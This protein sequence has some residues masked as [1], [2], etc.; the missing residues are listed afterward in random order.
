MF[1]KTSSRRL[2]AILLASTAL[3]SAAAANA[4]NVTGAVTDATDTGAVL[5]GAE[6]TLVEL[7]QSHT[8]DSDGQFRFTNIP[9]GNY[10]LRVT[11]T[12]ARTELVSI[13]VPATGDVSANVLLA[14]ADGTDSNTILVIGQRANLNSSISRQR[15]AD[16]VQTTLSRDSIGQFPDQNVAE[17]IRRAPGV[18]VLNDQGEGRFVSVRGLD[19]NLNSA[20]LN[21]NRILA[22]GGD[23]RAVALD[24]VPAE[25]I[26]SIDIK[27]SLTPDMDA[28]TIGASIEINTTSAFDRKKG[29]VSASLESSYND[30]SGETS[31]KGSFDFSTRLT[32]NLGV[33]GGLSY[34]NRK[35]ESDNVEVGSWAT[36]DNGVDFAEEIDYRDYDVRRERYGATL[37]FDYRLGENSS[38]YLR[39]LYSK[40]DDTEL[41]R[42]LVLI[43][44]FDEVS[45]AS[46]DTVT[47]DSADSRIEVR[48]DLKDR[49]EWQT[50]RTVAFGG[51]TFTGAWKFN[52][53]LA[54]SQAD[55]QEKGS[56]DPIRF[57][58]RF[59]SGNPLV[60]QFDYSDMKKPA[61]S[62]VGA[63]GNFNNAASYEMTVLERTTQE[64]AKDTEW[65]AKFDAAR[66]FN[67][68]SGSFELKFGAKLR[69]RDKKLDMTIDVYD[70]YEGSESFT[71]AD[72]AGTQTY[73]LADMGVVPD[74][75]KVKDFINANGFGDFEYNDDDSLL[76][77]TIEDYRATEDINAAYVLGR[78]DNG[79]LRVIGGVRIEQTKLKLNGSNVND[80]T[81]EITPVE[82]RRDYTD[83]LP[84]VNV[85]YNVSD[86]L[87][88]RVA[89]SQSLMRPSF[90]KLAPRYVINEDLEGEFGNPD[91]D[92]YKA[93]NLDLTL[94]Y[95]FAPEAVIQGGFF[96]KK[97]KDFIVTYKTDQAG[98]YHGIAY[99]EAEFAVN[100]EE[101][102]V[103]GFELA[104][105]QALSFLPSPWDG[106]LVNVNYTYT[107]A[108]GD[109]LIDETA[110]RSISLPNSAKHTANFVLGYE[111][112][113]LSLRAAASY[114]SSYLDEL[115]DL[116]DADTDRYV[117]PHTQIDLSAKYRINKNLRLFGE[118]VNLNDASY[119][120]YNNYGGR[121]RLLQYEEYSWT[122]KFGV[123]FNY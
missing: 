14:P 81:L 49:G 80:D 107:D 69:Q 27:K 37:N 70:S 2:T 16:G 65:S 46:G 7:N 34:Y 29:F 23:E 45:D 50:I 54:F 42:R 30:L 9:A 116:D 44:E 68:D 90:G 89:A 77:S 32:D 120:A 15:S 53:D 99:E 35:F 83:V 102:D 47:F 86:K 103:K 122:A 96:F 82:V 61:Y 109:I 119:T 76:A 59:N 123:K 97:I 52:Y 11:Y 22:T 38:M 100:G 33:A 41:R 58:N 112:G 51:K 3:V 98:T 20:S 28:D 64:D 21:G 62:V 118:L 10:T 24:V 117:R 43:T 104:Y 73:R 101:A 67:L 91:L 94:E 93:T 13:S 18:N 75:G 31:P 121:K 25:L 79:A 115:G 114:R 78:Y 55:Q 40:F 84:S 12:G 71:L 110:T 57:R 1:T 56:V 88:A 87:V 72:V 95:Y 36:D 39:T 85:R 74:L 5:R 105:S 26:E 66:N 108:E 60:L 63:P 17:S 19:P 6:V 48:R 113:P 4:G 106:L 111:K 8:V 92:P